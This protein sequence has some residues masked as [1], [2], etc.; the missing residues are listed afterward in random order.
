MGYRSDVAYTIRFN[1]E[2]SY[3]LFIAEAKAKDLGGCFNDG[4]SHFD[5]ADCDDVRWRINFFAQN[6]KWYDAFPEVV[7]HNKLIA[8]A[9]D[10]IDTDLHKAGL[11]GESLPDYTH[12]LGFIFTRIGENTDAIEEN[13]GGEYDWDWISVSRQII[14]DW[15]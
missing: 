10:W 15:S 5:E 11:E 14:T 6:V 13:A 8:L 12:R 3:R 4:K 2:A 7:M 1:D 9:E